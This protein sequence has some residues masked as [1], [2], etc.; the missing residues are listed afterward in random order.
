MS[1]V[2]ELFDFGRLMLGQ[3]LG[4]DLL[5][6]DLGSDGFGGFLVISREHIDGDSEVLKSF[7][8]FE[9]GGFNRIGDCY[10]SYHLLFRSEKHHGLPFGFQLL[11]LQFI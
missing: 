2:L 6:T 4:E 1:L 3:D 8:G 5:N 9:R 11:N 7:D 10:D